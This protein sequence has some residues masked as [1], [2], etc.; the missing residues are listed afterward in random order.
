MR[1][2]FN[3]LFEEETKIIEGEVVD[4]RFRYE[5][6][7][8]TAYDGIPTVYYDIVLHGQNTKVG[9]IDLRL[10]MNDSMYYYGHI[11]YNVIPKFRGH[12]Y[13]Y[14]ACKVLF[15]IAKSKYN[16]D[17]LYLTCNPDNIASYKTLQKLNGELVEVAQV[18]ENH[19][20]YE[21]GEKLKCIF[22]YKIKI[23]YA[24]N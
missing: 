23:Q 19:E 18:P 2:F 24:R 12:N 8:N 13:S 11:G 5:T 17:E 7:E 14:Y 3:S 1:K 10:K 6:D 16:L 21:R 4:L 15:E 20:L 22:R 9:S